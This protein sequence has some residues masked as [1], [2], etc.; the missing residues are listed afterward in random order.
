M[1][2]IIIPC[3]VIKHSKGGKRLASS[4]S[5]TDAVKWF[6][7]AVSSTSADKRSLVSFSLQKWLCKKGLSSDS[8]HF[9]CQ[10]L[11]KYLT[12]FHYVLIVHLP[13]VLP[14]KTP[15]HRKKFGRGEIKWI[16]SAQLIL[17]VFS[18]LAG[19][20]LSPGQKPEVNGFRRNQQGSS[21]GFYRSSPL[22]CF[23]LIA[24]HQL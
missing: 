14:Q 22:L 2:S 23:D 9:G 4:D 20:S 10:Y 1:S 19:V 6:C 5:L 16:K 13:H 7:E 15:M 18:E 8:K 12:S 11:L 24:L 21:L 17:K 3:V